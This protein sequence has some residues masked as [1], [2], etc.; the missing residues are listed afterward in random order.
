MTLTAE[1]IFQLQE[2][3]TYMTTLGEM[4]DISNICQFEW[5]ECVYLRQK[6]AVFTFKK[7]EL[8]RFLGPTKNYGN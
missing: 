2:H 8:G 1:N 4:G 3:N 7:E 6:T 5:Y